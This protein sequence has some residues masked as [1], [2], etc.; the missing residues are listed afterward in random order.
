[1]TNVI[2]FGHG[3]ADKVIVEIRKAQL[4]LLTMLNTV[5]LCLLTGSAW[6]ENKVGER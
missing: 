4:L 5:G 2:Q 6:S 1:M 3:L